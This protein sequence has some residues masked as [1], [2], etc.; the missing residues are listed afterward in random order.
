MP[1]ALKMCES[2]DSWDFGTGKGSYAKSKLFEKVSLKSLKKGDV[3]CSDSHVALY[4]GGGKVVQA[5]HEDDNVEHSESW[6]DSIAV[7][8]W[9]GY[10][11]A[12]RFRGKVDADMPLRHGEYSTRVSDLQRFLIWYGSKISV[13]GFFNSSTLEAVKAFQKEQKLTAD[14]IVG[15]KTIEAMKAV[16]K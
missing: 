3:L 1:E 12:Y 5:G 10:K 13:T 15:K 9:N 2:C 14:G 16:K 7:G 6:D 8:T 4:I 11:R